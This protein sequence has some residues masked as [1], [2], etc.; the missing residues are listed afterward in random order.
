MTADATPYYDGPCGRCYWGNTDRACSCPVRCVSSICLAGGAGAPL[1]CDR[2]PDPTLCC[3]FVAGH[4]GMHQADGH[5]WGSAR[6]AGETGD[7]RPLIEGEP[8]QQ[9]AGPDVARIR[10]DMKRNQ[11]AEPEDT[12]AL[13]AALDARDAE[14]RE[15]R[16]ALAEPAGPDEIGELMA[17]GLARENAPHEPDCVDGSVCG[18]PSNCPGRQPAGPCPTCQGRNRHTVDMVCMDC[19]RDYMPDDGSDETGPGL[20]WKRLMGAWREL[21]KKAELD[22]RNNLRERDA[23]HLEVAARTVERDAARAEVE[24]LRA[25]EDDTLPDEAAEPT[26]GQWIRW[27]NNLPAA[28]RLRWAGVVIYNGHT[29]SE[30]FIRNHD[31]RIRHHDETD[32]HLRE[33]RDDAR[34]LA[35]A[36]E[37]ELAEIREAAGRGI[38]D[39]AFRAQ[40][41]A[42]LERASSEEPT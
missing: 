17:A 10:A 37:A 8:A 36:L 15:L 29:A 6:R 22:A 12:E 7:L 11:Y 28:A 32:R 13:I 31:A 40:V 1:R 21:A 5:W 4:A 19:G 33:Q 30:C 18:E 9:P 39:A 16:A 25:G 42:V 35:A 23:A 26:P 41:L 24:R 38:D 34:G 3:R 2:S 20:G 14:I 27:W